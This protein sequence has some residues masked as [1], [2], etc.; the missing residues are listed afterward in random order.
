M[1]GS[2]HFEQ[3]KGGS[4]AYKAK[5]GIT[6]VAVLASKSGSYQ[7]PLYVFVGTGASERER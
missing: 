3:R 1:L 7:V 4:E 2:Q 6:D 5:A